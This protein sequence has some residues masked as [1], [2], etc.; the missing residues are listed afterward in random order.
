MPP[1]Q[2]PAPHLD[3]RR[4]GRTV[5]IGGAGLMLGALSAAAILLSP[6]DINLSIG[7]T[8]AARAPAPVRYVTIERMMLPVVDHDGQLARY[9]SLDI[10]LSV[11][12]DR[13]DWVKHRLPMIRHAINMAVWK[14]PL[15]DDTALLDMRAAADVIAQAARTVAG[16]ETIRVVHIMTVAPV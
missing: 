2:A 13:Q 4:F 16:R 15:A 8:A 14:T 12:D 6:A 1:A 9:V 5:L 10:A 3:Q 7:T 11:A